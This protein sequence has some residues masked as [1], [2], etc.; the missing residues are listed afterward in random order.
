M[1]STQPDILPGFDKDRKGLSNLKGVHCA[2]LKKESSCV[3]VTLIDRLN[4]H[5][6]CLISMNVA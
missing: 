2:G 5:C 4:E 3:Q 1:S 6:N